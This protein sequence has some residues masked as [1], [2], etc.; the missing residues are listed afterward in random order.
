MPQ[1]SPILWNT[2]YFMFSLSMLFF[3]VK[4]YFSFLHKIKNP[5]NMKMISSKKYHWKW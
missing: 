4:A 3:F 2:L 5:L 1:M